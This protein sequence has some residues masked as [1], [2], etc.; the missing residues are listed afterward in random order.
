[1]MDLEDVVNWRKAV[2]VEVE[3]ILMEYERVRVMQLATFDSMLKVSQM[4]PEH[5]MVMS[6]AIS[7]LFSMVISSDS[8]E[9]L[10]LQYELPECI[11]QVLLTMSLP[12]AS[13]QVR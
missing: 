3:S 10:M 13:R 5:E 8:V 2:D 1:M 11:A 4:E 12:I 6:S 9:H 7:V